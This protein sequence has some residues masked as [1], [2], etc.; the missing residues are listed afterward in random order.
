[1]FTHMTK[2]GLVELADLAEEECS[3]TPS[4]CTYNDRMC[5]HTFSVREM[6]AMVERISRVQRPPSFC[7]D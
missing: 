7:L 6:L 2:I 4:L 1:M 3:V 5:K